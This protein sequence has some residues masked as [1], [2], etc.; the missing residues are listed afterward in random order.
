MGN[1]NYQIGTNWT[2]SEIPYLLSKLEP[3]YTVHTEDCVRNIRL[4]PDLVPVD[5]VIVNSSVRR[6]LNQ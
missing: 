3:S 5:T 6:L 4:W 2:K 1:S